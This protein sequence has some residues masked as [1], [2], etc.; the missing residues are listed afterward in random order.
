MSY[1]IIRKLLE[2]QINSVS[3]GF[4]TAWE[5]VPFTP[6]SGT[7]YQAITLLP[8]RTE[9]PTFG[10]NFKRE[11][12]ILQASLYYPGNQGSQAAYARAGVLIGAF[13]RGSTFSQGAIKIIIDE[14]PYIGP[15]LNNGSWFMVPVSIPFIAD[16]QG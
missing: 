15:A 16:I 7:P 1:A 11:T 2:T 3:A 6:T 8:A 14:H 4:S 9:G 5:N 13:I 10:S 12:G